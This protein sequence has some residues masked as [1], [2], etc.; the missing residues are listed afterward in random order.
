MQAFIKPLFTRLGKLSKRDNETKPQSVHINIF[1][2]YEGTSPTSD[3]EA[4]RIYLASVAYRCGSVPLSGL[5]RTADNAESPYRAFGLDRLYIELDTETLV[6][7]VALKQALQTNQPLTMYLQE[8]G[9]PEDLRPLAALEAAALERRMVLLGEPGSGKTTFANRLCLALAREDWTRLERWPQAMRDRLPILVILRDF[10]YWLDDQAGSPEPSAKMLDDYLRYDLHRHNL[11]FAER[12]I[13]D[14]L[15]EGRTLVVLDGLDE[16]PP[17][18]RETVLETVDTF[19]ENYEQAKILVTC[20]VAS[21]ESSQWQLP[22]QHFAEFKLSSFNETKIS[23]FIDSWYDEIAERRRDKP[24][25]LEQAVKLK[26]AVRRRDLARLAPNPLLLTVMALV[27]TEDKYL[28][29]HRALLYQRAVDILLWRWED[30]R[31]IPGERLRDKLR[32]IDANSTDLLR[33]LRKLAF[34]LHAENTDSNDPEAV[35]QYP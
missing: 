22:K 16:V 20:R 34:R 31:D 14:A 30:Q 15:N 26:Y 21:Y 32:E 5:D 25:T 6:S 2:G 28:P 3:A 1:G 13:L 23:A 18:R 11:G 8:G 35:H 27:H 4:Q 33:L 19:A 9:R 12:L 29:E 7:D 10:V 24:R 17:R